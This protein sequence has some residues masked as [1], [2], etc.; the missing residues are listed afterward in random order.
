MDNELTAFIIKEFS[1]HRRRKDIIRKVCERGGFNW[2]DAERLTILVEARHKHSIATP[3]TPWLLF[4]S[5]GILLIG[6][7]LLVINLQILL[8]FFQ[9]DVIVQVSILQSNSYRVIGFMTGLGMTVG[10][11]IGLWKAFDVIF[12][13]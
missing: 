13:E 7:G 11:M 9:K 12:P 3:Q 8:E 2:R 4:F 6:I 10:G 5:I 1:K